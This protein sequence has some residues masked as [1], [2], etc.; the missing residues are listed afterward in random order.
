MRM[1][2]CL[3]TIGYCQSNSRLTSRNNTL[4]PHLNLEGFMNLG[5]E[6]LALLRL[7]T[8]GL[9]LLKNK[10]SC[11]ALHD[12]KLCSSDCVLFRTSFSYV[13]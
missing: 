11:S 1:L 7:V 2:H 8:T 10:N 3:L 12:E 5:L 9:V 13:R 6:V 4:R